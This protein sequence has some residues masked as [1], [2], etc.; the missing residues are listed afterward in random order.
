MGGHEMT[1]DYSQSPLSSPIVGAD[2]FDDSDSG[3]SSIQGIGGNGSDDD[4]GLSFKNPLVVNILSCLPHVVSFNLRVRVFNSLMNR[5]RAIS[6][7]TGGQNNP[8]LFNSFDDMESM[9]G[10]YGGLQMNIR[11]DNL[12]QDSFQ[13]F[14]GQNSNKLKKKCKLHLYLSKVPQSLASMVGVYSKSF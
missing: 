6:S 14:K 13:Q 3:P 12:L 1:M 7:N 11:R 10:N 9:M 2:D 4:P 5:D 8:Q